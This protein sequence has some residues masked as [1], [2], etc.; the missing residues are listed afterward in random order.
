MIPVWDTVTPDGYGA[1]KNNK[2]NSLFKT[3]DQ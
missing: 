3:V 2:A 1:I